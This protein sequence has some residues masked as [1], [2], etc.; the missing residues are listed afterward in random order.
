MFFVDMFYRGRY[1]NIDIENLS[2]STS[3]IEFNAKDLKLKEGA[4][5]TL[6]LPISLV[7]GYLKK[8]NI[9]VE[10]PFYVT[11]NADGL[12]LLVKP[13][14]TS[15]HFDLKAHQRQLIALKRRKLEKAEENMLQTDWLFLRDN[16]TYVQSIL[17]GILK[18]FIETVKINLRSR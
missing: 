1:I 2:V 10:L 17:N 5:D 14:H 18:H 8:L 6:G 15:K 3:G 16:E 12:Y 11:I 4:L 13:Q 9:K 7:Y